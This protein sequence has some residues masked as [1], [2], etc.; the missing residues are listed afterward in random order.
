MEPGHGAVVDNGDNT[1]TYTPAAGYIG[2]DGFSYTISDGKGGFDRG[3]VH[4]TVAAPTS[5][6]SVSPNLALPDL[7]TVTSQLAVSGPAGAIVTDVNVRL[8]INH[9]R[10]EDLDVFLISPTGTRI[11]LFTDIGAGANFSDTTLDDEAASAISGGINPYSGVYR[12][13]GLL[14][15]V[16][17]Q[18]MN[19]TWT[20]EITD[21]SRRNTGTLINWALIVEYEV[22]GQNLTA[23]AAPQTLSAGAA[24]TADALA[25]VIEEAI[26]RWVES[27]LVDESALAALDAVAFEIADLS[28]LVLGESDG[29]TIFIDVDAAGYGWFVDGSVADDSEFARSADGALIAT[30]DGEAAGRMDLLT[31]VMHEIGHVL[32]FAHDTTLAGALM[33]DTLEAGT[34]LNPA[35]GTVTPE[36][37][38]TAAA[39]S[40]AQSDSGASI[41]SGS[42]PAGSVLIYEAGVAFF[43]STALPG[44]VDVTHERSASAITAETGSNGLARGRGRS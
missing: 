5:T 28:G 33:E 7:A 1:Y 13:E 17:G 41:A 23:S 15:A 25:P 16:D 18:G 12:P 24:L 39:A 29:T 35:T 10:S 37:T 44:S 6:F 27:G 31:V 19:G 2:Q 20:L 34:R 14:S 40:D 36:D 21:D 26:A 9:A 3:T 42:E 4:I 32:G 30:A 11:E 22:G 43:W 8:N 38:V